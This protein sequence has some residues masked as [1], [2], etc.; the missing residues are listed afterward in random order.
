MGQ[1]RLICRGVSSNNIKLAEEQWQLLLVFGLCDDSLASASL[2]NHSAPDNF[3]IL[4]FVDFHSTKMTDNNQ[5][6]FLPPR[7]L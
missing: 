7:P 1:V 5:H 4:F 2:C 6:L 3:L